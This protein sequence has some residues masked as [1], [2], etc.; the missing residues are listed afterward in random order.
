[1]VSDSHVCHIHLSNYDGREHRLP[2]RGQLDLGAVLQRLGLD[3]F[4]GTV[5][6]ELHPDALEYQNDVALR[7]H[8]KDSVAFCREHLEHTTQI[9]S[10]PQPL[11]I[12]EDQ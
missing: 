7:H 1:M 2:H 6:N 8:L 4:T 10:S 9:K 11:S 3:G 12:L 5:C